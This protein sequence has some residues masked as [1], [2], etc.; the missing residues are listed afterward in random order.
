MPQDRD[1]SRLSL[2]FVLI[3][4]CARL[5]EVARRGVSAAYGPVGAGPQVVGCLREREVAWDAGYGEKGAASF[6]SCDSARFSE[7]GSTL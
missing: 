4:N 2:R 1:T 3:T 5:R 7:Q 6:T